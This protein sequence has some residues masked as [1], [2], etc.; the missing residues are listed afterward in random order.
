MMLSLFSRVC[1]LFVYLIG[2]NVWSNPL[3]I[4]QLNCV[5]YPWIMFFLKHSRYKSLTR[6]VMYLYFLSFCGLS[7]HFV[8]GISFL[9][10]KSLNLDKSNLSIPFFPFCCFAI[11]VHSD[12]WWRLRNFVLLFCLSVPLQLKAIL[13]QLK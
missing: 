9:K 13:K 3:S 1:W 10:H 2:R 12:S 5:F 4:F 8:Y 6:H 11:G 7:L